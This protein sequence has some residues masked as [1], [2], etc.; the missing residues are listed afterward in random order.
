MVWNLTNIQY[1]KLIG[2]D[3]PPASPIASDTTP[4]PDGGLAARGQRPGI[5]WA[6][7]TAAGRGCTQVA[8]GSRP[9]ILSVPG[10]GRAGMPEKYKYLNET[11]TLKKPATS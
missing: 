1:I 5:L 10:T 3:P 8:G 9:G 4:Y 11:N 7:F 2:S 6:T